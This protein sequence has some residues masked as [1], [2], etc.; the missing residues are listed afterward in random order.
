MYVWSWDIPPSISREWELRGLRKEG[1]SG[2]RSTLFLHCY[3]RVKGGG[4]A[5]AWLTAVHDDVRP[6]LERVLERWRAEGGVD[7]QPTSGLVHLV[8]IVPDVP[9]IT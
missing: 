7:E 9:A 4:P 6:P 3:E 8:C 5:P 1:R 2:R